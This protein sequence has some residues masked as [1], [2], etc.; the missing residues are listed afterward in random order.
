MKR[1]RIY[2]VGTCM[3]LRCTY[4]LRF[5]SWNILC[6]FNVDGIALSATSGEQME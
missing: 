1:G 3:Y 6:N 2:L 5:V 4:K